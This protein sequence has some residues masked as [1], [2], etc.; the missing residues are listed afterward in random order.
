[1]FEKAEASYFIRVAEFRTGSGSFNFDQEF[2]R[3]ES[4]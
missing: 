4:A 2:E 1:M 3:V